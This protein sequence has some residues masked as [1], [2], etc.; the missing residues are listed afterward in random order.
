MPFQIGSD[1][2]NVVFKIC[3]T[4]VQTINRMKFVQVIIDRKFEIKYRSAGYC[5]Y[6]TSK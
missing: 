5:S 4:S 6:L 3:N 2:L 1:F